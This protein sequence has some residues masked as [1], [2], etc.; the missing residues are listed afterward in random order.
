[1]HF[2]SQYGP[3]FFIKVT[4]YLV[5]VDMVVERIQQISNTGTFKSL[6]AIV[7]LFFI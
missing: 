3:F 5:V 2:H 7:A 4:G 1:M 6:F